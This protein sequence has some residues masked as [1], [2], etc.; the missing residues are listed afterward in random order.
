MDNKVKTA[1]LQFEDSSLGGYYG[2]LNGKQIP[3]F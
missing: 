3:L 2:K 1:D